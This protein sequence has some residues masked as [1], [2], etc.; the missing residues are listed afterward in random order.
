MLANRLAVAI[1]P[2][3]VGQPLHFPVAKGVVLQAG[4][5]LRF[6]PHDRRSRR[7]QVTEL[8]NDLDGH[9]L[10]LGEHQQ[11]IAHAVGEHDSAVAHGH[12]PQQHFGVADVIVVARAQ[13]R[14][15]RFRADEVRSLVAVVIADV[16]DEEPLLEQVGA[17]GEVVDHRSGLRPPGDLAVEMGAARRSRRRACPCPRA[18]PWTPG[19]TS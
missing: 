1:A 10:P 7:H 17:A 12:A 9:P 6:W 11:A 15:D 19:K 16:G 3:L 14:I 4:V 5:A 2:Q 13:R 18:W 8:G